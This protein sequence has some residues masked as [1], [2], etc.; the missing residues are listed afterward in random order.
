[1]IMWRTFV[2]FA[3]PEIGRAP[4]SAQ[5][6]MARQALFA[7]LKNARFW[8]AV[9]LVWLAFGAFLWSLM[10]IPIWA[11]W[12]HKWLGSWIPNVEV[13]LFTTIVATVFLIFCFPGT[14]RRS[15][16]EQFNA[17][18]L[19]TCLGCGYDLRGSD[20]PRCAECGQPAAGG[21]QQEP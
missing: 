18:G 20:E 8:H 11:N 10:L 1:M 7:V 14:I 13:F 19:R 17:H 21:D 6:A 4:M 3:A 15:V 12:V 16:R 9:S 2:R 5:P